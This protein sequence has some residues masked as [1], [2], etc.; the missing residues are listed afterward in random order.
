[1]RR[2]VHGHVKDLGCERHSRIVSY[3]AGPMIRFDVHSKYR[4]LAVPPKP[5]AIHGRVKNP[6]WPHMRIEI[7]KLLK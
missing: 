5:P 4:T 7:E 2:V 6:R 1:M 3:H